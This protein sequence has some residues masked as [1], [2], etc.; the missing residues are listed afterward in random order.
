MQIGSQLQWFSASKNN[1]ES[2]LGGLLERLVGVLAASWA[3]LWGFSGVLKKH[4]KK[5]WKNWHLEASWPLLAPKNFIKTSQNQ[6]K[7]APKSAQNAL[8]VIFIL[9]TKKYGCVSR[10]PAVPAGQPGPSWRPPGPSW[11]EK[12]AQDGPKLAPKMEA[13]FL[14]GRPGGILGGSWRHH[15]ADFMDF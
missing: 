4:K 8:E 1:A 14:L 11:P 10:L 3:I 6:A 7:T 12:G 15:V 13:K 2:F 5:I 9:G